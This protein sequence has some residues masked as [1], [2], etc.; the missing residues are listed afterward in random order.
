[1][2]KP[3]FHVARVLTTLLLAVACGF[4]GHAAAATAKR[5][6]AAAASD[7]VACHGDAK[8]LPAKHKAVK[9]M[10]WA[11][12]TTCH[13]PGDKDSSLAGKMPASHSHALAGE[14]CAS[15]HGAG[16]P[17]AVPTAKCASCHDLDKL[18]AKTAKLKPK[19]PHTSPHYGK[20][21]DCDN[22]HVQHGKS[23]NFCN[24]CHEFDFRVP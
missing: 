17:S 1:M 18:V 5:D 21:L 6:P 19:N 10:K 13:E 24:D 14:S 12:C 9:G 8:V 23:V 20:E 15:C 22:C 7:C 2:S 11:D 3:N 16:K 4:A